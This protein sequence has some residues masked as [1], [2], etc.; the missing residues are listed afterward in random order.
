[1]RWRQIV[2]GVIG[3]I[4][5]TACANAQIYN[6]QS[7]TVIPGTEDVVPGPGLQLS[8]RQLDYARLLGLDLTA[9]D[10]SESSLGSA[11]FNG[12]QLVN[13]NLSNANLSSAFLVGAT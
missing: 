4:L 1:M 5:L 11:Q 10:F 7:S 8:G 9:S 3:S 13:V 2:A 12:S 6:W